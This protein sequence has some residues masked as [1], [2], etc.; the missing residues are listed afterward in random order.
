MFLTRHNLSK[1]FTEYL[2]FHLSKIFEYFLH[3][4]QRLAWLIYVLYSSQK[5]LLM[6]HVLNRRDVFC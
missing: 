5:R 4:C 6:K 3:L 2:Y 1:I